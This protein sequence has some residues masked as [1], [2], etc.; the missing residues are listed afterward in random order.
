MHRAAWLVGCVLF[1]ELSLVLF[2]W[3]PAP[4]KPLAMFANGLPLGSS[5]DS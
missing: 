1:S 2:A 3:V 5:G 4:W